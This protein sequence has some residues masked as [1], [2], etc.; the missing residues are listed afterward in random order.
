[1]RTVIL[2]HPNKIVFGVG[3]SA[4]LIEDVKKKNF[5][6][7][8]IV[9]APP[10]LNTI[11]HI[12]EGLKNEKIGVTVDDTIVS[13]PTIESFKEC[14]NKAAEIKADCVVGIGGGSVLDVAKLVSAML[15]NEQKINDVFGIDFL[16]GRKTFLACLPTTSGTGSEVSPN[17]ILLDEK[18][19]LKKGVISQHL[20]PDV[21]YVDPKLTLSVPPAVTAA[22]GMD[23]LTHCIEAYANK[24]AH[25][26]IDLYALEGIRLISANLVKAYQKGEDIE[27]RERL[28][29]GS[30]FGG[31]CLGP[32]NTGAVHALSYPLGGEFH[33]AHGLSN[34]LLLPYVIDFNISAA[35]ERYADIAL[36][37]GAERKNNPVET[38]KAGIE[39]LKKLAASC[40]IPLRL[41]E[42]KIPKASIPK[43]AEMAITIQRLLKNNLKE[44]SLQDAVN[45]YE[46]AY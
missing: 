6:S 31:L 42:L 21:S 28:S 30:M 46:E 5:K 37:L 1:M 38:A 45:I 34:A 9:T 20:L 22:T 13:E 8:F 10:I 33:V 43:M 41:S 40:G 3:S 15:N 14:L 2:T 24:F 11:R 35:P 25:P 16:S 4:K 23:A 19:N 18:D 44:V 29:L 17:A 7:V 26:I 36:A 39:I 32:V 27:A 12:L